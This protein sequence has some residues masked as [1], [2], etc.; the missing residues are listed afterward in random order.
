VVAL[1]VALIK[2]MF[3]VTEITAVEVKYINVENIESVV[4]KSK[5]PKLLTSL[6][7]LNED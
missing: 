6:A 5:S 1:V 3:Y 4:G 7:G 2:Q